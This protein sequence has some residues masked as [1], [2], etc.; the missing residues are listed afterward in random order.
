[1]GT[2]S[3]FITRLF[4]TP[5]IIL[6]MLRGLVL[7]LVAATAVASTITSY[8]AG[9]R[10]HYKYEVIT[11]SALRAAN[12][13][14]AGLRIRADVHLDIFAN[15]MYTFKF[16]NPELCKVHQEVPAA[17]TVETVFEHS[18]TPVTGEEATAINQEL[19]NTF[20][21]QYSENGMPTILRVDAEEKYWSVNIKRGFLNLFKLNMKEDHAIDPLFHLTDELRQR[22][23]QASPNRP[24][25]QLDALFR[26]YEEDMVGHCETIYSVQEDEHDHS[27]IYVGKERNYDNCLSK[28][29]FRNGL[30]ANFVDIYPEIEESSAIK[31]LSHADYELEGN[32]QE[33]IIKSAYLTNHFSFRPVEDVESAYTNT[34]QN[35]K[36]VSI[37]ANVEDAPVLPDNMAERSIFKFFMPLELSTEI[38]AVP[39]FTFTDEAIV[40]YIAEVKNILQEV[41]STSS[42]DLDASISGK[43]LEIAKILENLPLTHMK[44]VINQFMSPTETDEVMLKKREIL[45]DML[46]T[47]T[48]PD[49]ISYITELYKQNVIEAPRAVI[50]INLATLTVRPSPRVF[51]DLK[52]MLDETKVTDKPYFKK[53]VIFNLGTIANKIRNL[54]VEMN[55]TDTIIKSEMNKMKTTLEKL[56][57]DATEPRDRMEIV[58]MFGNAGLLELYPTIEEIIKEPN[59]PHYL[60]S[61]AIYAL[62]KMCN[63]IPLEVQSLLLPM[64]ADDTLEPHVR[65]SA[66]LMVMK[67]NPSFGV[68]QSITNELK[69]ETNVEVLSFVC[70]YLKVIVTSEDPHLRNMT[71]TIKTALENVHMVH[72]GLLNS[73]MYSFEK[74]IENAGPIGA[75]IRVTLFNNGLT[76][77]PDSA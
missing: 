7:A 4:T 1:M 74:F 53:S 36:L 11:S 17:E 38:E 43:L 22:L 26:T 63:V 59:T 2:H 20:Q 24:A 39:E 3:G 49:I 51:E 8:E 61:K 27:K 71:S 68:M 56:L 40:Y 23:V 55:V 58:A 15:N 46:P 5:I 13:Q 44:K 9:H 76:P 45:L 48:R 54:Y 67:T 35:L 64:Y 18:C 42:G 69:K 12:H 31:T 25:N 28:P 33:Y 60:R 21:A 75:D 73:G 70:S 29:V 50:M 47:L 52:A 32:R 66:F 65:V 72:G 34:R 6:I 19:T 30:F 41:V 10:Y 57:T 77:S 62:R 14:T 37:E 16:E